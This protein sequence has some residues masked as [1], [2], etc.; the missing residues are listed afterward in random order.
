MA[1]VQEREKEDLLVLNMLTYVNRVEFLELITTIRVSHKNQ[2][3]KVPRSLAQLLDLIKE[4]SMVLI[5][6]ALLLTECLVQLLT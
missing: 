6:Q 3:T 5:L 4:C 1:L 2:N